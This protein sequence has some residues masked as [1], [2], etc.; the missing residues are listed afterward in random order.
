MREGIFQR[1]PEKPRDD[2]V[3]QR[4]VVAQELVDQRRQREEQ[5]RRGAEQDYFERAFHR[6]QESSAV[7][8][9]APGAYPPPRIA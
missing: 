2:F 6:R 1:L 3:L 4:V 8:A 5:D 9:F 7:C